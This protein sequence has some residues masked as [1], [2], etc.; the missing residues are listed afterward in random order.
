VTDSG[1][2]GDGDGNHGFM[3]RLEFRVTIRPLTDVD[4]GKKINTA[5]EGDLP[6]HG[7]NVL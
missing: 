5:Q 7:R 6:F 4:T 3:I 2:G 1:G